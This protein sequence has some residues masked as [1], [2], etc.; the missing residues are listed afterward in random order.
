[1]RT[2]VPNPRDR[3]NLR[4]WVRSEFESNRHVR[5]EEAVKMLLTRG[6]LTMQE[7]VNHVTLAR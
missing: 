3:V 2:D 7:M 6:R 4:G 5:D 1:M